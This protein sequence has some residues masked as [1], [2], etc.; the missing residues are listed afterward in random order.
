MQLNIDTHTRLPTLSLHH[1]QILDNTKLIEYRTTA[2]HFNMSVFH[3]FLQARCRKKECKMML[4]WCAQDYSPCLVKKFRYLE[5]P[6][7]G[8]Q[9][10]FDCLEVM[11]VLSSHTV[12]RCLEFGALPSW[13][14]DPCSS[15]VSLTIQY[16]LR[17]VIHNLKRVEKRG[18]GV[19]QARRAG[20]S[21]A[22]AAHLEAGIAFERRVS[23]D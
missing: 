17:R 3:H 21:G 2:W 16:L 12:N 9:A 5:L 10:S 11:H 23:W 20:V 1:Q 13:S 6:L 7:H 8:F 15:W 4:S 18:G 22:C 19:Q 14:S